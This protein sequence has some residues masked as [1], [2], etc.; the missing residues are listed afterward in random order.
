MRYLISILLVL[1][2]FANSH[3]A[4]KKIIETPKNQVAV[5]AGGCFWCM[6]PPYDNLIKKG[7]LKVTVGYTG[8]QT[9]KPTY[10]DVSSGKTGHFEAIEVVY[11]PQKISYKELLSIFWKNIDPYNKTGQFCDNGEEYTSAVF[12]AND[13]QKKDYDESL[14]NI[15][16]DGIKL[17]QVT[18]KVLPL[19]TFYAG[20]DYHQSYYT[21]N[22]IRYKY[23]RFNCG[24]DKRLKEVWGSLIEH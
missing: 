23:Y 14:K 5:F 10:E 4:D 7:V 21:K 8:G 1:F 19:K 9:E 12:F 16:K 11:N 15:E 2:S 6:Q 18:T 17:A 20:E 22:P 24:R 3:A 13:E